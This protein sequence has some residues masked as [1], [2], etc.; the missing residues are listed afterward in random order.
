MCLFQSFFN[1][2]EKNADGSVSQEHFMKALKNENNL[3]DLLTLWKSSKHCTLSLFFCR[4]NAS[5]FERCTHAHNYV[6]PCL[7][8]L[9]FFLEVECLPKEAWPQF[10]C[11]RILVERTRRC[12]VE[13][14]KIYDNCLKPWW[15]SKW[16]SWFFCTVN[17]KLLY[18]FSMASTFNP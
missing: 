11:V 18:L 1:Q 15:K 4:Q 6:L 7:I 10:Q 3:I 2:F 5:D 13:I 16:W 8:F 9:H 14:M 12:I 17:A